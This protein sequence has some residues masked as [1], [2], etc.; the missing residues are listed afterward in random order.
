MK[1]NEIALLIMIKDEFKNVEMAKAVNEL[2]V[3]VVAFSFPVV[4]RGEARIRVQLSA[5]HTR[6]QLDRALGVFQ[7]AGKA[8]GVI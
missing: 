1:K 4:P 6:A 2:G 3:F 8:L 5:V 7:E